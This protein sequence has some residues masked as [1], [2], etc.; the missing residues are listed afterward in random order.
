MTPARS[1][2][3]FAACF[4]AIACAASPVAA[5]RRGRGN[6][7]NDGRAQTEERTA[8]TGFQSP[9]AERSVAP[10]Q[11]PEDAIEERTQTLQDFE[12]VAYLRERPDSLGAAAREY[13]DERIA[14][15]LAERE[16]LRDERREEAIRLLEQFIASEPADAAE[17]PDALLRLA[18]LRFEMSRLNYVRAFG[19]WQE[20]PE[21]S[22][23]PEPVIDYRIPLELYERLLTRYP[24]FDRLDLVLYMKAYALLDSGNTPAA[25]ASYRRILTQ[26]PES[27]FVPDSHFALAEDAFTNAQD[28]AAALAEYEA[29]IAYPRSEL[30]DVSL[31]KSAWC[32]WRMGR[33][34]Q[35]AIRFRQVLDLGSNTDGLTSEQRRRLSDLQD[36]A[37]DYL[38]QV[39]TEDESNTAQDVFGFLAGI[40]GDRYANRVLRRLSDTYMTQGRHER[41]IE[42]YRLLLQM[43]PTVPEAPEYQR[44]IAVAYARMG[45]T[46]EVVN[47]LT[48]LAATYGP[49]SPW[50]TQQGDPEAVA[51]TQTRIERAIR[52]QALR[53]HE[54]AQRD[55][56]RALFERTARLYAVYQVHFSDSEHAYELR[57]YEAEVLFHRLQRYP[58]AGVA[59]LSAARMNPQGRYTRDALYNAIGAFERVREQEITA[60]AGPATPAN[61]RNQPARTPAPT[62]PPRTPPPTQ[63]TPATPSTTPATTTAAA[64]TEGPRT[65]DETENDRRF[66]E[67][68]ALYVELFPDD[69]DLPEILFRQGRLYYDRRIYDPAIRLFGQLIERYPRSPFAVQAGEL[70]LESFN[71]ARD[72]AN[73]E[74]WARRLKESPAFSSNELQQKLDRLILQAVFARG[75]QLAQAGS[76]REAAAAYVRAAE[77]FPQDPRARQALYNAGLESQNA[78]DLDGASRAYTRLAERY[79]G[80]TEG[81]MGTWQGAQ[82]FESIAQFRDAATFYER[83]GERFPQG[84]QAA[85]AMYNAVV[86][87]VAAHDWD[88]AADAARAFLQRFPRHES[89][90]DVTFY[91]ARALDGDGNTREAAQVYRDY[92]RRSRNQN[93]QVE[94]FTRLGQML[95]R[96]G[97]ADQAN[98]AFDEAVRLGKRNR[99]GLREGLY[100]AAQARFLQGEQ[101][102]ERFERIPLAGDTATLRTRLEQKSGLLREA[103]MIFV[104]TVSFGVAEWVTAALYR[105][106]QSYESFARSMNEFEI[107]EGLSEAEEQSYRDQ[108]AAFVI[109]MEERALESYEGGYRQAVELRIFNRWTALLREGLVR[110]NEVE[111]PP[112]REIGVDVVDTPPLPMPQPLDGLR[113]RTPAAETPEGETRAAAP[114]AS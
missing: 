33:T 61:G 60:C 65:C 74:T 34:D 66:S 7:G 13:Q 37:L 101:V 16:N 110:L 85:D 4:L 100:F 9:S 82:M 87:R 2:R 46:D 30:Y 1:T 73:I 57:F 72:Y 59:Y 21:A 26:Y 79:A 108:L 99:R 105:I 18:E 44:T 11:E 112:L 8:E 106:G 77:E 39:F 50:A 38:I 45:E 81:A 32:M 71:R 113:R 114:E 31:F 36:E 63:P 88:D 104:D 70:I 78:G 53:F 23:G 55:N 76:H 58:E 10:E 107:P 19:A 17:M 91:L 24:T 68:I 6:R 15:L 94:A 29:V 51:H 49:T 42:A 102:L 20:Q 27:R 22:R 90:D 56:D 52:R 35:A 80:T 40:G 25:L 83:Y 62:Q 64:A 95:L 43:N 3:R 98:Q 12:T 111:N 69:P 28:F 92:A 103:A 93:R 5:Q 47:A 75:E 97:Q 14:E 89:A 96:D 67:A 48:T 54:Q 84:Q 109:P 86:L 41:A